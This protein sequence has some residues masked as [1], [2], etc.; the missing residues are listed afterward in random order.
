MSIMMLRSIRSSDNVN[1][2]LSETEINMT[3]Y[4]EEMNGASC[5]PPYDMVIIEYT[6]SPQ[7]LKLKEAVAW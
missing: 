3:L 4:D 2:N 7:Y 6:F 1:N 5:T